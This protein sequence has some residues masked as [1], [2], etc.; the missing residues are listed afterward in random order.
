MAILVDRTVSMPENPQLSVIIASYNSVR[1]IERCLQSLNNQITPKN[2]EIIVVDSSK[3]GTAELVEEKFRKVRLCRFSKRKFC[4]DARNFGI[5]V[6][7]AKII[8]FIDADCTADRNWV[9]EILKAHQFPHLAIGG[10][11]ANGNPESY[12]GWA[13]YFC[14]FSQWMPSRYRRWLTDIPGASMSYKRKVFEQYSH[15]IEGTYCS[16]TDFH[17]RLRQNGHLLQFVPSILVFHRNIDNFG[18]FLKHEF[19]HG[20]SFGQVRVKSQNFSKLRRS[21]YVILF[22]L[23][24]VKL[25]L[26]IGLSNF[27]NRIYLSAFL[28][29]SPLLILGIISWSLGECVGYV[30]GQ[31]NEKSS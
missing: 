3:D 12:V 27:K 8:A 23:I 5:S 9:N 10:S 21:I 24:S 22:F 11:I 20:R 26:G 14:E 4:G 17:W 19:F 30:G 29:A 16:D 13:A 25:F 1:T 15:F 28:K 2:F 18:R 31:T 7:R 6:A